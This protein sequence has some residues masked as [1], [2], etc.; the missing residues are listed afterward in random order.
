MPVSMQGAG[1]GWMDFGAS[2][3]PLTFQSLRSPAT[4]LDVPFYLEWRSVNEEGGREMIRSA[5]ISII[6]DAPLVTD[7]LVLSPDPGDV[8]EPPNSSRLGAAVRGAVFDQL[9]A[10]DPAQLPLLNAIRLSPESDYILRNGATKALVLR[11]SRIPHARMTLARSSSRHS[12][13]AKDRT[14]STTRPSSTPSESRRDLR[15]RPCA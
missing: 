9:V 3:P 12:P 15:F 14:R 1:S 2:A 11:P 8:Y 10:L 5:R 4:P 7:T 13:S 6:A